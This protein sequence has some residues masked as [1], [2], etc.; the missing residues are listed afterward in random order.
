MAHAIRFI[1]SIDL[2]PTKFAGARKAR[3]LSGLSA[4]QTLKQIG[5]SSPKA[6]FGNGGSITPRIAKHLLSAAK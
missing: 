5:A 2:A 6:Q 3:L 4:P 1:G